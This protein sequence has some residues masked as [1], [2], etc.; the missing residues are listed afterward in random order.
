ML[1]IATMSERSSLHL[2]IQRMADLKVLCI[3]DI[4]LDHFIYG[5]VEC[6]SP[7][8]PI[9]VLKV[10]GEQRMLGGVGNVA[11]NATALGAKVSIIAAIGNDAAGR[12]VAEL[13]EHEAGLEANFVI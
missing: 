11:R 5:S 1:N 6:I 7:E 4:M 2:H 8:A 10:T 13:V 9:P 3:G 12:T